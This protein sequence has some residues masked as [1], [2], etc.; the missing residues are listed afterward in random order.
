MK[1]YLL[2]VLLHV[3]QCVF[4]S[5]HQHEG[6]PADVE[7]RSDVQ[8]LGRV[9]LRRFALKQLLAWL[10]HVTTSQKLPPK[11]TYSEM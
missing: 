5:I 2:C 9:A 8:I 7:R 6:V 11:H 1:P 10:L 4:I 3:L